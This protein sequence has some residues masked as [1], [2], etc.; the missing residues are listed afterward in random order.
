MPLGSCLACMGEV[1]FDIFHTPV[2]VTSYGCRWLG[3]VICAAQLCVGIANL[4]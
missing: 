3:Y 1:Y 4:I 2:V